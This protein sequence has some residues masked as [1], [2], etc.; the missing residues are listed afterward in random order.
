MAHLTYKLQQSAQAFATRGKFEDCKLLTIKELY[1]IN[2]KR[3]LETTPGA[4]LGLWNYF[5]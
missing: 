5:I 4:S 3:Q 2:K 1:R